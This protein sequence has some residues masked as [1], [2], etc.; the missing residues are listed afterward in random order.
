MKHIIID[1]TSDEKI[2]NCFSYGPNVGLWVQAGTVNCFN[3]STD[4]IGLY[5]IRADCGTET[6]VMNVM[7]YNGTTSSGNINIY[8]EMHL[9]N[10]L[11]PPVSSPVIIS[12]PPGICMKD[13]LYTYRIT[14]SGQPKPVIR[15]VG[16]PEWLVLNDSILNGRTSY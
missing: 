13:S 5:T 14:T 16:N 11:N 4:N 15:V 12:T 7:R 6:N 8:N 9:S 2:M 1:G 3:F 10:D